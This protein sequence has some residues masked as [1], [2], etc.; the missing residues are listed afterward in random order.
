MNLREIFWRSFVR[1]WTRQWGGYCVYERAPDGLE[2]R[3]T[4]RYITGC[5]IKTTL[6]TDIPY[7]STKYCQFCGLKWRRP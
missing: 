2:Q 7:A 1:E 3:G 4:E 5:G 6:I